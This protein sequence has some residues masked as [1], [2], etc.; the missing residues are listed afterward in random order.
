MHAGGP[1]AHNARAC[2]PSP[3]SQARALLILAPAA[4]DT[5]QQR[6]P[7]AQAPR[8]GACR[9]RRQFGAEIAH[10][11]VGRCSCAAAGCEHQASAAGG[12]GCGHRSRWA[13]APTA[14]GAWPGAGRRALGSWEH[15][16]CLRRGCGERQ[17]AQVWQDGQGGAV[18]T[19]D[20]V[21]VFREGGWR[22]RVERVRVAA[23]GG[24]SE[25]VPTLPCT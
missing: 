25:P 3:H 19:R 18:G 12:V 8:A 20:L 10:S 17:L 15:P 23:W 6:A 5:S 24:A 13:G 7:N 16:P 9:S 14:A 1:D 21:R 11:C 22:E 2:A 4:C